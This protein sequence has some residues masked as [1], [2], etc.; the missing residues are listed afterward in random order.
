MVALLR[1]A[2]YREC[3]DLGAR[4]LKNGA[5][6]DTV[7]QLFAEAC[8]KLDRPELAWK[9][10]G[11]RMPASR[12][13]IYETAARTARQL[14]RPDDAV[15]LH[16]RAIC[17]APANTNALWSFANTQIGFRQLQGLQK[18]VKWTLCATRAKSENP[19]DVLQWM[20]SCGQHTSALEICRDMIGHGRASVDL[21]R[22][23]ARCERFLGMPEA[24]AESLRQVCRVMPSDA[25]AAI[26]VGQLYA[27]LNRGDEAIGIVRSI[28]VASVCDA[29]VYRAMSV[30]E[31]KLGAR[32]RSRTM[33]RFA[34]VIDPLMKSASS[35]EMIGLSSLSLGE[36]IQCLKKKLISECRM[37]SPELIA[38][39]TLSEEAGDVFLTWRLSRW[40]GCMY[41]RLHGVRHGGKLGETV[42]PA[43]EAAEVGIDCLA[44]EE[45][46]RDVCRLPPSKTLLNSSEL[47]VST[48]WGGLKEEILGA[49]QAIHQGRVEEF[50]TN[51]SEFPLLNLIIEKYKE[52]TLPRM[53]SEAFVRS[54][55]R[56]A[57]VKYSLDREGRP[58]RIGR[59]TL[60][61]V[62]SADDALI[63]GGVREVLI[64]PGKFE[65]VGPFRRQASTEI[66][67]VCPGVRIVNKSE[68]RP[69][70]NPVTY[71]Y[72]YVNGSLLSGHLLFTE[73]ATLVDPS[74]VVSLRDRAFDI[75][76]RHDRYWARAVPILRS[77]VAAVRAVTVVKHV[78]APLLAISP[79]QHSENFGH[80]I[81]EIL[82]IILSY[83]DTTKSENWF[84]AMGDNITGFHKQLFEL[85]GISEKRIVFVPQNGILSSP[86][87]SVVARPASG[88]LNFAMLDRVRDDYRSVPAPPS[89]FGRKLYLSRR[90]EERKRL[91]N[92]EEIEKFLEMRG[93]E[94][95]NT[96]NLSVADQIAAMRGADVL[97]GA[98]GSAFSSAVFSPGGKKIVEFVNTHPPETLCAFWHRLGNDYHW[99]RAVQLDRAVSEYRS[100]Y[101]LEPAQLASLLDEM[102]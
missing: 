43:F 93:F 68:V 51:R 62:V 82:P 45:A 22:V 4:V 89:K 44:F 80:F 54:L 15:A 85:F 41:P 53:R 33:W 57:C 20:I 30:I 12:H 16:R 61:H 73:K 92:E 49:A 23:R 74:S 28:A 19:V 66:V 21:Y 34:T 2:H 95:I 37:S 71:I 13:Q 87:L 1:A 27:S 67:A 52:K 88:M 98:H 14:G 9:A 6:D 102:L 17:L 42:A 56:L 69:T 75:P 65:Y 72:R 59:T 96:G 29:M 94:V 7:T 79:Y 35:S 50:S 60:S 36:R 11:A 70:E 10:L 86:E 38:L 100:T 46:L 40:S 31:G 58:R 99:V 32:C 64:E 90:L 48:I 101:Y 39:I 83:R 81:Y 26:E 24:A 5:A 91:L 3:A 84:I 18:L 76:I 78:D 25:L 55:V 47:L 77:G 97:V 8:L 63:E